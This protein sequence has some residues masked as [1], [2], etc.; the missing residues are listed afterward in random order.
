M[1]VL[2]LPNYGNIAINKET[3]TLFL[4]DIVLYGVIMSFCQLRRTVR[5]IDIDSEIVSD[6]RVYAMSRN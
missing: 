3:K 4:L 2:K 6:K 1:L 5:T